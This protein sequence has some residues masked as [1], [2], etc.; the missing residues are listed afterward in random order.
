MTDPFLLKAF[1]DALFSMPGMDFYK[2]ELL[3]QIYDIHSGKVRD[4]LTEFLYTEA[5][6]E[7]LRS[8]GYII[9]ESQK[10]LFVREARFR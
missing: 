8:V 6:D 1:N 5:C 2:N 7:Y 3:M 4:D 9:P 10:S